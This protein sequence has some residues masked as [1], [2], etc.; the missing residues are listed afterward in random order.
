MKKRTYGNLEIVLSIA[1]IALAIFMKI[2]IL[3]SKLLY[4]DA[5]MGRIYKFFWVPLLV[6]LLLF[7]FGVITLRKN[8]KQPKSKK[9]VQTTEIK[10]PEKKAV[11]EK[12][13][14]PVEDKAIVSCVNCGAKLPEGAKF[15]AKCG[16]PVEQV[17][18][19]A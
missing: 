19:Q 5:T 12:Q 7:I 6:A 18:E 15:C 17:K 4:I 16:T 2:Q 13:T 14:E 10:E 3:G 8:P 1:L 11:E 9:E